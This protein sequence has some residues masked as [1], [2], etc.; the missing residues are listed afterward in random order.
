MGF[1]KGS[2]EA[3]AHMAKL[4]SMRRG[5]KS[6]QSTIDNVGQKLQM[7][8]ET[9]PQ[10]RGKLIKGSSEAKAYM[11]SIRRPKK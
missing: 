5:N 8:E 11:A 4:R 1:Q 2:P 3:I 7:T 10:K 6:T 9:V